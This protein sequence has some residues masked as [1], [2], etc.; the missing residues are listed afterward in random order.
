[1]ACV[2]SEDSDQPGHPPSLIK[3]LRYPHEKSIGTLPI[4]CTA[5]ALIRLGRCPG[6]SESSLG[7]HAI[8]LSLSCCGWILLWLHRKFIALLDGVLK[9]WMLTNCFY[10]L[11]KKRRIRRQPLILD[12]WKLHC[13]MQIG[14]QTRTAA[15]TSKGFTSALSW[16]LKIGLFNIHLR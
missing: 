2:L 5:K 11:A 4:E 13:R 16:P 9:A 3:S 1:M 14:N 15:V 6:W 12:R 8:L 10:M 7:T